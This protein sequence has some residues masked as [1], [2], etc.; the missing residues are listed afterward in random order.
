MNRDQTDFILYLNLKMFTKTYIKWT[1][2]FQKL[3]KPNYLNFSLDFKKI[4]ITSNDKL[5]K[6]FDQEGFVGLF[7]NGISYTSD[8][9]PLDNLKKID[10]E[11]KITNKFGEIF[12]FYLEK[13]DLKKAYWSDF[14]LIK[15]S[16]KLGTCIGVSF[17]AGNSDDMRE[18]FSYHPF[19]QTN[20]NGFTI[21]HVDGN[22]KN[23][24]I[25]NLIPVP[26]GYSLKRLLKETSTDILFRKYYELENKLY[27]LNWKEIYNIMIKQDDKVWLN[28]NIVCL[29]MDKFMSPFF[30]SYLGFNVNNGCLDEENYKI[31][32]MYAQKFGLYPT[33]DRLV[34]TFW[35]Y[36]INSY[37]YFFSLWQ[38]NI[39]YNVEVSGEDTSWRS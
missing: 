2:D 14:N 26:K 4:S 1:E 21:K 8:Y 16:K 11:L 37:L 18:Y 7:K 6:I 38:P 27:Y 34:L 19:M 24:K 35:K 10:T 32:N 23:L 28:H 22:M 36:T 15:I 25:N 30:I 3:S 29:I 9:D 12:T 17:K 13:N 39:K 5:E 20:F 31:I 33:I